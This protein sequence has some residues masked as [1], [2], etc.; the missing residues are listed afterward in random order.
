[1][2]HILGPPRRLCDG[3]TRRRFLGVGAL[4]GVGLSLPGWLQATAHAPPARGRFGRAR[5][6]I[7]LFLTGGPPQLDTSDLK[8]DL[9]QVPRVPRVEPLAGHLRRHD[10][11]IRPRA[12]EQLPVLDHQQLLARLS[13]DR[14]RTL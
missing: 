13:G 3:L 11:T 6:C 14:R 12:E 10:V 5:R 4:G 1:M 7:L 9:A 2:F 8:P